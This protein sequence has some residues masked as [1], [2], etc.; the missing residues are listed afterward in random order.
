MAPSG[1][2]DGPDASPAPDLP[3]SGTGLRSVPAR[4]V[5]VE[6]GASGASRL[7]GHTGA[8]LDVTMPRVPES[9]RPLSD[10]RML[11]ESIGGA[12][13]RIRRSLGS[14]LGTPDA[15]GSDRHGDRSPRGRSGGD[16]A[17]SVTTPPL[18]ASEDGHVLPPVCLAVSLLQGLRLA[19]PRRE[20]SL[21]S[22]PS[23]TRHRWHPHASGKA[24]RWRPGRY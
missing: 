2:M 12:I 22:R 8:I 21:A 14:G 23:G 4:P 16:E 20:K 11:A 6:M 19:W 1:P 7:S 18:R 13:A 3:G 5:G 15:D 17:G 24:C 10:R 9:R